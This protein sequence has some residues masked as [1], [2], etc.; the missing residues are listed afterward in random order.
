MNADGINDIIPGG[1]GADISS[2]SGRSGNAP[3][4]PVVQNFTW[5]KSSSVAS[6]GETQPA[7]S[8]QAAL[9]KQTNSKQGNDSN[10]HKGT[11]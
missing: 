3:G 6:P 10:S 4:G 5:S 1:T 2:H 9:P 7:L 11:R 8:A